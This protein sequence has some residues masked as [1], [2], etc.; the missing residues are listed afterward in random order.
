MIYNTNKQ[1]MLSGRR[2]LLQEV[3]LEGQVEQNTILGTFTP[4]NHCTTP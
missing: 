2:A 4:D 3:R 1:Y